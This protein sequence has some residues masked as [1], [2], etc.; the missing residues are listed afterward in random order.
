MTGTVKE[1]IDAKRRAGESAF[2]WL[3][4]TG[5][6]ALY[7]REEDSYESGTPVR[8]WELDP[9]EQE[10]LVE[11]GLI[12]GTGVLGCN[13]E[14]DFSKVEATCLRM[15]QE[16]APTDPTLFDRI[17]N[18]L[19]AAGVEI[20]LNATAKARTES[21]N[22]VAV[23]KAGDSDEQDYIEILDGET[24]IWGYNGEIQAELLSFP[25]IQH[26][27][28]ELPISQED[29]KGLRFIERDGQKFYDEADLQLLSQRKEE[30]RT[31]RR[32]SLRN[33]SL[34]LP[35]EFLALCEE[36]NETPAAILEGFIADL[37]DLETR[38]YITNGSD[39]RMFAQ[40]YFDRCGYRSRAEWDKEQKAGKE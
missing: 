4:H 27:Y 24:T 17:T 3:T 7:D 35:D 5:V 29:L 30:E 39:E 25:Q 28:N 16:N 6:C 22:V 23:F 40:Q 21:P 20:D 12:D 9:I 18:Q 15:L 31:A 36:V 10:Q 32:E 13:G 8:R 11:T 1:I 37:C 38:P 2:L 26:Y 33:L 19:A 34:V 14:D